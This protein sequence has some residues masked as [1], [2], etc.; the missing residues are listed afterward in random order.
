MPGGV[1]VGGE[2]ELGTIKAPAIHVD[3]WSPPCRGVMLWRNFR[4]TKN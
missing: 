4:D 2:M 3:R 1:I